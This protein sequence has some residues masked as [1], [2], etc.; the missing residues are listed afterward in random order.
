MRQCGGAAVAEHGCGTGGEAK[1][2]GGKGEVWSM[3]GRQCGSV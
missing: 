1:A 2:D 3:R